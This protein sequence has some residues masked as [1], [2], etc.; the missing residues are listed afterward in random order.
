[1][2]TEIE[3]HQITEIEFARMWGTSGVVPES[4]KNMLMI[5][6]CERERAE[7]AELNRIHDLPLLFTAKAVQPVPRLKA[8]ISSMRKRAKAE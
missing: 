1:M 6:D 5:A 7:V 3:G 8:M 4:S 2:K